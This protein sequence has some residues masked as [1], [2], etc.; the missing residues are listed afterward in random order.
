MLTTILKIILFIYNKQYDSWELSPA[1]DITFALNPLVNF[2]NAERVL[3]INGK[4]TDIS[5][6]DVYKLSEAF[7]I[8]N[9]ERV[10]RNVQSC[11]GELINLFEIYGVPKLVSEK[12]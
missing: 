1:Y 5:L 3:Y 6:K 7:T 11:K 2:T 9:P 10:I 4:R 12:N 8:K